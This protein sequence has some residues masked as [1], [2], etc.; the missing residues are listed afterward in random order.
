MRI[1]A[2]DCNTLQYQST[3]CCYRAILGLRGRIGDRDNRSSSIPAQRAWAFVC[4]GL[5]VVA[6]TAGTWFTV[7]ISFGLALCTLGTSLRRNGSDGPNAAVGKQPFQVTSI[8]YGHFTSLCLT[9][10]CFICL[11][12]YCCFQSGSMSAVSRQPHTA[13]SILSLPVTASANSW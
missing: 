11:T 3:L 7:G 4:L 1:A 13:Q 9:L 8:P 12:L 10:C 6:K 2:H 5:G